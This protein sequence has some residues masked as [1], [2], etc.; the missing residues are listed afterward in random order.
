MIR[1]LLLLLSGMCLP[2]RAA[3]VAPG[4]LCVGNPD[5]L[6]V[7]TPLIEHRRAQG[8][9]V[10]VSSAPV[11]KAVA[12]C[13]PP[14]SYILLLGDD[15]AGKPPEKPEAWRLPAARRPYHGWEPSHPAEFVSDMARGDFD[16]DGLPEASV[17]RIPARSVEDVAA[18]A[19]KILRWEKRQPSLS[20]LTLPVWA[21]DP[22]F[23][24]IFRNMALG[25]LFAQVRQRSP[26]W[27]ELWVQQSDDRSPFCGWPVEQP[28]LFNT[29]LQAGG[30]VS[31]MIGHG[32]PR[33]WWC[34]DH[35]GQR[36]MYWAKDAALMNS[37]SVSPPH[38]IFAC[39]CGD[40]A[41]EKD[42]SLAEALFRA[43]A[44]PVLCAAASQDSH[45]LTN[46]YHSTAL[47]EKLDSP[48]PRFGDLWRD[49][50]RKASTATDPEKE[51][52]VRALEPLMIKKS[53]NTAELRADHQAL[54]N[55]IGDPATRLFAPRKLEAEVSVKDGA[56][57]FR[58]PHPPQGAKL[59]VQ[60]RPPLPDFVLSKPAADRA[61]SLKNQSEANAKLQFK[62]V[63]E[64]KPG[65]LWSGSVRGP[66]TLRL[67]ALSADG[68]AVAAASMPAPVP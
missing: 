60:V 62:T 68:L 52:L 58:I 20:D 34:M 17:G 65:T 30:L 25:F 1:K 10:T 5:F 3:E 2:L 41:L 50:L 61:E 40:F 24:E 27:A 37:G 31:A 67:V 18:G 6:K 54:Y 43:P 11:E 66:G 51:L 8:L 7:A 23:A 57:Q 38:I 47:L 46:Y 49:S 12:D 28:S 39:S 21:G 26:L 9:Q 15:I 19:A 4:W 33:S 55:I 56:W 13:S 44:G 64:K 63:S 14:P 22:G 59:V 32:Q 48:G 16:G 45:P 42:D 36:L 29:R 53:L 35:A